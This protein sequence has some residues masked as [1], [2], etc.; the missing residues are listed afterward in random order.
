MKKYKALLRLA[1]KLRLHNM[2]QTNSVAASKAGKCLQDS[3]SS[4]DNKTIAAS[5]L[6]Q[7]RF[8]R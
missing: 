7:A 1:E 5:A 8:K 4:K 3:N 2:K 6:A